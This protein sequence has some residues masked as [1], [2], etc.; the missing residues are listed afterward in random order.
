M[1]LNIIIA[2]KAKNHRAHP[3]KKYIF[4]RFQEEEE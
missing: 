1:F 3:E 4:S 2:Q